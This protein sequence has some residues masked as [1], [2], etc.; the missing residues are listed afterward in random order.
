M[1]SSAQELMK[2]MWCGANSELCTH[3]RYGYKI[4]ILRGTCRVL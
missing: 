2:A 1:T 3:R 4:Q